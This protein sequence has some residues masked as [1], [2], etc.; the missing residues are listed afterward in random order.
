MGQGVLVT[1]EHTQINLPE[2]AAKEATFKASKLLD[3]VKQRSW[4][5]RSGKSFTEAGKQ[6]CAW[7]FVCP[8]ASHQDSAW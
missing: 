5:E 1:T 7:I 8:S 4:K 2:H 3:N 6:D